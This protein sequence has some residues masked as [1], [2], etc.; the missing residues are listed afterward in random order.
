MTDCPPLETLDRL[1]HEALAG[2]EAAAIVE[3]VEGCTACQAALDRLGRA[4]A[5]PEVRLLRDGAG[6]APLAWDEREF[7]VMLCRIGRELSSLA[8][9][10]QAL[11][12]PI[13]PKD[14]D[15][16]T[17]D[18]YTMLGELGAAAWGSFTRLCISISTGWSLSR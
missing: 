2:A 1:L 7:Q 8:E 3:H 5:E 6:G 18:G 11:L 12:G 14:A 10:D 16:P 15:L 17:I 13:T 4:D 9:S